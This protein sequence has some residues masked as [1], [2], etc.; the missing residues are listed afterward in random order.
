M[1]DV[2]KEMTKEE[3]RLFSMFERYSL[4]KVEF[5]SAWGEICF[6]FEDDDGVKLDPVI[7]GGSSDNVEVSY[8]TPDEY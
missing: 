7:V 3:K 2:S 4:V 8:G 6:I 5:N 1:D